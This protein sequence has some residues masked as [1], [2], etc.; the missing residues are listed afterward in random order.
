MT[1]FRCPWMSRAPGICFPS[2]SAFDIS[3]LFASGSGVGFRR[4]YSSGKR[5]LPCT[6]RVPCGTFR[7]RDSPSWRPTC[8]KSA[9]SAPSSGWP[10]RRRHRPRLGDS[11]CRRRR[12]R[13][14]SRISPPLRQGGP[15]ARSRRPRWQDHRRRSR[16]PS[17]SRRRWRRGRCSCGPAIGMGAG[18]GRAATVRT[19]A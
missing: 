12:Q 18:A 10:R 15:A 7:P 13:P 3:T 6:R 4:M 14:C 1:S 8:G 2:L 11:D 9:L 16:G 17:Y 5:V 19:G